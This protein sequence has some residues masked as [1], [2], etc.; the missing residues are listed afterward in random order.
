MSKRILNLKKNKN[1]GALSNSS[2]NTPTLDED[3]QFVKRIMKI[4]KAMTF[5]EEMKHM[6]P[7]MS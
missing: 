5:F 6:E 4:Y 1:F 3:F 2:K 7:N